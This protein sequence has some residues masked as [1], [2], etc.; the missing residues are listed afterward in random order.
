MSA[1]KVEGPKKASALPE[2]FREA[3]VGLADV[4]LEILDDGGR[5]GELRGPGEDII[6]REVVLDHELS[7]ITDDL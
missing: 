4:A 6:L 1:G 3:S 5:E 2:W 7:Q